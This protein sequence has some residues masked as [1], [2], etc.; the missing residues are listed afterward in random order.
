M[1]ASLLARVMAQVPRPTSVIC[2]CARGADM[3]GAE[4]AQNHGIPITGMA[5]D[6]ATYGKAA[7]YRRNA[8]MA[9]VAQTCVAFWDGQSRGTKHMIDL[10][11]ARHLAVY[12][13]F[14]LE[15]RLV[16]PA[17]QEQL[18]LPEA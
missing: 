4:W 13:Y 15:Q 1:D 14:Y 11:N 17:T 5:A 16:R 7:G 18:L 2:G 10:A 6:W 12:I 9:K 3:L 8:E